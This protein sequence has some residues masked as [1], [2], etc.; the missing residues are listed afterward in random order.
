MAAGIVA[1]QSIGEPGTQ[2]TMRTFHLGGVAGGGDITQGLPRVEELFEARNPKRQAVLS[3]VSGTIE[4]ED[5]DGKVITNSTGRKVF[6]GRRGQKIIKVHF[7]GTE[8]LEVKIRKT[9]DVKVADGQRVTKGQVLLVRGTSGEEKKALYGGS[10]LVGEKSMTLTYEGK[11][12]REYIIPLGLK[13]WV[14]EGDVVEKGDQLTEGSV[15]LQELFTLKNREAVQKYILREIKQI[16]GAQ[17]QKLNDKHLEVIIRQLFSRVF[18]DDVGDTDL[19][20]G[21]VIEKTQFMLANAEVEREG[22]KPA[23]A[24]E[25]FLGM[26]KVSLSTQSFL[27]AASFQET[28]R[29]L[30][31]AAVTGKVDYLEGLK[32]NVI[33]GRL[34]PVG[35][36]LKPIDKSGDLVEEEP[37][38]KTMENPSEEEIGEI[39][40][41]VSEELASA[42]E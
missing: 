19:I 12:V 26:S 21:E 1:A 11:H 8:E 10:V 33:I 29:V 27:S 25:L 34:I 37:V 32:E 17:G 28:A 30:V 2:L 5:A 9:D 6:E 42:K 16:Y 41:N 23:E 35:T 38:G 15:N 31:N 7:E 3:E 20:P 4:I 39:I 40:E 14:K 13:L 24:R 36:G 18:V 22:K